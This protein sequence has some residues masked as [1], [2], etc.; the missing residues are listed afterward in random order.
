MALGFSLYV[1][2]LAG[3]SRANKRQSYRRHYTG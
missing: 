2:R 1:V 3:E